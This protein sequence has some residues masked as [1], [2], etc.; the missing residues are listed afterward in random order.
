MR[1]DELARRIG[2]TVAGDGSIDITGVA[3][4]D[5]AAPNELSFL[6]NSRYADR[7]DTTRAGAVCV[8]EGTKASRLNCLV[9]KDPYFTF[10]RAVV[11]VVGHRRHPHTGIHPLAY[12]DPSARVGEGT[13][14]YPFAYVGPDTTVGRDCILFPGA[15][16]Y[17]RCV[18]GDRVTLHA[19]AVIG[20]DGFGYATHGGVH[21]K[22]P[23]AG[24][25]VIEDDVEIGSCCAIERATLG[26]TVIAKGT[27]F[28]DLIGIGHGA[29]IGPHN[30]FV[31][32]VGIA[33]STT[34][35]SYVT[36]GGQVGVAGHLSIGNQVKIGAQS[37]VMDDIP[38]KTDVLGSPAVPIK[39]ARKT[40]VAMFQLTDLIK[41]MRELE[42]EVQRL[43]DSLGTP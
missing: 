15:V 3:T 27:K 30:L 4:L 32:Q 6:A 12:V 28:A 11:E 16:V 8:T 26:S 18:L 37:G 21:H 24:N 10:C 33:G 13:T 36:M 20:Q 29:K 38:D 14:V 39:E 22:I 40:Y 23:Q 35:G 17:D 42:R 41:R 31:S 1:L 43:R 25:V 19:N 5:E 2:A 34:T 7:L 9:S